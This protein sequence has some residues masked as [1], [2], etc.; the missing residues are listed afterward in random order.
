MKGAFEGGGGG[1]GKYPYTDGFNT[2][3]ESISFFTYAS[4]TVRNR[5]APFELVGQSIKKTISAPAP[6][7][8]L[9]QSNAGKSTSVGVRLQ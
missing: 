1:E 7:L 5:R 6:P 4:I 8:T 9:S 3:C 2:S